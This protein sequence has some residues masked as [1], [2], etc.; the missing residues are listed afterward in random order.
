MK[1][2]SGLYRFQFG[3]GFGRKQ[4]DTHMTETIKTNPPS[5]LTVMKIPILYK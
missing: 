2:I 5:V 1:Q 3:F 4:T